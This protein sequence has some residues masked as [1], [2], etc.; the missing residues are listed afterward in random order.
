MCLNTVWFTRPEIYSRNRVVSLKYYKK[1]SVHLKRNQFVKH[2]LQCYHD[3]FELLLN[4]LK[5][6]D[7]GAGPVISNVITATKKASEIVMA[8]YTGGNAHSF[9]SG[10]I[11]TLRLSTGLRIL[12]I[13]MVQELEGKGENEVKE[14]HERVRKLVKDV[15]DCDIRRDPPEGSSEATINPTTWSCACSLVIG[16]VSMMSTAVT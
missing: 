8:E 5:V 7:Y 6:L 14:R 3:A 2:T 11:E 4:I 1:P 9:I 12:V 15:V 16:N 13:Y 10:W